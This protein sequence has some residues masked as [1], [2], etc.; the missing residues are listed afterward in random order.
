MTVHINCNCTDFHARWIFIA[1]TNLLRAAA[2]CCREYDVH[3]ANTASPLK[4]LQLHE[5]L[6]NQFIIRNLEIKIRKTVISYDIYIFVLIVCWN[7]HN[8]CATSLRYVHVL[9]TVYVICIMCSS[10]VR[11]LHYVHVLCTACILCTM[12]YLQCLRVEPSLC[13]TANIC[14][15]CSQFS[16]A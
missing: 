13:T 1:S 14:R 12:H 5:L 4:L 2:G 8:F 9:C 16:E 10:C 11:S 15:F 7:N 3:Y 6:H